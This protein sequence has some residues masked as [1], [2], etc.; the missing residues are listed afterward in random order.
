MEKTVTHIEEC[1]IKTQD[2][3]SK[4]QKDCPL[5]LEVI[6]SDNALSNVLHRKNHIIFKNSH[7]SF[8][9]DISPIVEGH[10][11]LVTNYHLDSFGKIKPN[12]LSLFYE[13]LNR[14]IIFYKDNFTQFFFYEHGTANPN[15]DCRNCVSHAHI[16]FIPLKIN[17]EK[18][19]K[20]IS[21]SFYYDKC[22]TQ[23]PDCSGIDEYIYFNQNGC[24][25][26]LIT[27]LFNYLPKQ[28]I[29]MVVANEQSLTDWNWRTSIFNEVNNK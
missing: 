25:G 8:L 20:S 27:N 14:A 5:C 26:F 23:Y 21:N 9:S 18:Y 16:H 6:G 17:I 15:R 19:I 29:R 11:L 24:S 13:F 22:N 2:I 1:F 3:E 12:H 10:G 28:F 4:I 7:F